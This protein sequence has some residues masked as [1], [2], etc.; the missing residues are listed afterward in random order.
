MKRIPGKKYDIVGK[1]EG[2]NKGENFYNTTVLIEDNQHINIKLEN[3][4]TDLALGKMYCFTVRTEERNENEIVFVNESFKMAEEVLSDDELEKYLKM[5]YEYAPMGLKDIKK[6][7]ESFLNAIDNKVIYEITK[8]IYQKN[9]KQ[10]YLHP[11]A[12]KFHHSYFG[13]LS[14]HTLSMLRLVEGFIK[15]YPY[16][17]KDLLY[18][19]IILHD[20][21]K[22]DE[23]SGVDGEYTKE[24]L[25]VGHL[26]MGT[27]N[28]DRV[29]H[30]LGYQETE[31][32]LMLKHI[33]LSHHGQLIYGAAKKPQTGEALL[34]WYLDTIDS[35]LRVLG[36]QLELTNEGSF[37][38]SVAVLDKNRFYKDKIK[39]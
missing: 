30:E 23:I 38:Q 27:V 10:F 21:A 12:T 7:V 1:V 28:I 8:H 31:E 11:A 22:I 13:G 37:T 36:E 35:K 34:L 20:M 5:F 2:I 19:G 29:A 33:I 16:L 3:N 9:I 17:N 6:E 14:Y 24:G 15:E 4:E 32:V 18:S 25:L 39:K 26:V